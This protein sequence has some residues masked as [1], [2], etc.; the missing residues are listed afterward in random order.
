MSPTFDW[1]LPG[2]GND[3]EVNQNQNQNQNPGAVLAEFTPSGYPRAEE[4]Y[5]FGEGVLSIPGRRGLRRHPAP[6]NAGQVLRPFAFVHAM[7]STV[8]PTTVY[9]TTVH[10]TTGE[11]TTAS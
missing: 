9:P 3:R 1:F 11:K 7:P 8:H 6:R 10:P 4:P 5:W 2:N